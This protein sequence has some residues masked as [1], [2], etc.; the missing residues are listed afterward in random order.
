MYYEVYRNKS[1]T[2]EDFQAINNIY[3]R[4]MSEDKYLCTNAHKNIKAGVFVNGELHPKMEQGPLFFQG[5]VRDL[6]TAHHGQEKK[7]Q[8][9]I[10]PARQN[11]PG[12]AEV[13]EKD[14]SFCSSVECSALKK[15]GLA[16]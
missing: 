11:L 1:S 10:W 8:R 5:L 13:S 4:I 14:I 2:D 3:K 12:S 7:A 9:E 16:W 15:E 6:V